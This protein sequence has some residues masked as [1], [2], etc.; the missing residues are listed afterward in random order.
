VREAADEMEKLLRK[1]V[2]GGDIGLR[3]ELNN[4]PPIKIDRADCLEGKLDIYQQTLTIHRGR[5]RVRTYHNVFCVKDDVMK[6]VESISKDRPGLVQR[7]WPPI[8]STALKPAPDGIIRD[9]IS[10][11]Y[12]DAERTGSKAPNLEELISPVRERLKSLDYKA[13]RERIRNIGSEPQFKSRRGP[14]GKRR[15]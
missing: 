11:V 4:N 1:H 6:I 5:T 10:S 9:Q 3:G 2:H 13:S 8:E 7:D 15:S 12:S 14:V